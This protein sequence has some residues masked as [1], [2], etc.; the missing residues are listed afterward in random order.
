MK[1]F[2]LHRKQ[3]AAADFGGSLVYDARWNRA[4][5]PMLYA[6]S[7][8]SLACLEVLVH[9]KPNQIPENYVYSAA[10]LVGSPAIA[11]FRGDAKDEETTRQFGQWWANERIELAT[12]V[13]SAIIPIEFNI[14]V[15]PTHPEFGTVVWTTE[16]FHFD[17][18]LLRVVV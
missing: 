11:P 8:L 2:R 9:L 3:R 7:S 18:R 12:R 16:P 15:N 10:D 5:T 13:P 4:G 14:L 6:A 17:E 1:I